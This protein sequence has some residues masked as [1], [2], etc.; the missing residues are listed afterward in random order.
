MYDLIMEKEHLNENRYR[1]VVAILRVMGCCSIIGGIVLIILGTVVFK[2]PH[3]PWTRPNFGFLVPGVF[4]TMA[5]LGMLLF[6]FQRK[7]MAFQMQTA[8]PVVSEGFTHASK[9]Q[10]WSN[11]ASQFKTMT[12]AEQKKCIETE[13]GK[14]KDL[15]DKNLIS[16]DEY[17][18]MRKKILELN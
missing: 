12:P 10:G 5:G 17:Q 6:S 16:D 15:R 8:R 13:L 18:A 4:I 3:G 1:K 9:H 14:A 11:I 7:M 2:V